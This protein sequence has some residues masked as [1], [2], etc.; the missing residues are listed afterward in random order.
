M[1]RRNGSPSW[2]NEGDA[3]DDGDD[4]EEEKSKAVRFLTLYRSCTIYT[5]T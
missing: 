3:A 5:E 2:K 4:I 1:C